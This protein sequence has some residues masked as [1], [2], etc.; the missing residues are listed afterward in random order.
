MAELLQL[1]IKQDQNT[2]QGSSRMNC[3]PVVLILQEAEVNITV[4]E[5]CAKGLEKFY[6]AWEYEGPGESSW[7]AIVWG[8]E[9]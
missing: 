7:D 8:C 1:Q 5:T 9:G 2:S 3:L 6:E 4:M